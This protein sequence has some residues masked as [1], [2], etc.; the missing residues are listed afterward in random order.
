[1]KLETRNKKLETRA[2]F[3]ILTVVFVMVIFSVLGMASVSLITNSA[4]MM[5]D[6]YHSAQA[7]D[8]AEAGL[9]Y[10]EMQL[11][12]DSDW[13]DN[14]NVTMNFGPGS[15]TV[16]FTNK[17]STTATVESAGTVS[18]ITRTLGESLVKNTTPDAFTDALYTENSISVGG[19]A[20]GNINGDAT[21]GNSISTGGMS[22]NGTN[23]ANDPTANCP[24]PNWGYWAG[25]ATT[26]VSGNYTFENNTYTGI[27]Y[28]TGNVTFKSNVIINGSVITLGKVTCNNQSNITVNATA[29]NPAIVA[30]DTVR[31]NGGTNVTLN[32]YTVSTQNIS[33]EG[34]STVNVS[35]G[36]VSDGNISFSG[37]TGATISYN[38]AYAPTSGF[39]GG[40][41]SGSVTMSSW[42][43]EY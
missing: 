37:T 43:E 7:Y 21:A 39:T 16:T 32:G 15:F 40:A 11:K 2:G 20:S 35:G 25:V 6:E 1:M 29:P 19:T 3:A 38:A 33:L 4:Q 42:H 22:F 36:F 14:P 13:S 8:V 5:A 17:T 23:T 18:A 26:T 30:N 9:A 27:Y 34:N 41:G 10:I 12:N 28:I 31:I 24:V